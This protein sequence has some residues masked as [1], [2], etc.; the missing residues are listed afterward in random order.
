MIIDVAKKIAGVIDSRAVGK[1]LAQVWDLKSLSKDLAVALGEIAIKQKDLVIEVLAKEFSNF[2]SKIN[3]AEETKKIMDGMTL[4]LS[5]K[6]H[7]DKGK[8][9]VSMSN[10]SETKRKPKPLSSKKKKSKK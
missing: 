8:K 1:G 4:E 5:A 10:K 6:V 2:L 3:I 7:F 9:S